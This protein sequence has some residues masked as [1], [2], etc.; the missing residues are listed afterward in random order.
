MTHEEKAAQFRILYSEY[1][2]AP[3]FHT[4][5]EKLRAIANLILPKKKF[6]MNGKEYRIEHNKEY[7]TFTI[8]L[9]SSKDDGL[10]F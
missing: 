4:R 2:S 9:V 1:Q 5:S 3:N 10:C 6:R 7:D 8:T